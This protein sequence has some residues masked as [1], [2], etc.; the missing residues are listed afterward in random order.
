MEEKRF[1]CKAGY[2][3]MALRMAL[4]NWH[5]DQEAFKAFAPGVF[6]HSFETETETKIV[7]F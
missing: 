7:K 3:P 6:T 2:V 4:K 5:N 1:Y